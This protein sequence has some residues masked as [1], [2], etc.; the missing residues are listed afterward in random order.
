MKTSRINKVLIKMILSATTAV[1]SNNLSIV[2]SDINTLE[3][4]LK[5]SDEIAGVQFCINTSSDITLGELE[6]GT[7]TLEPHWLVSSHKP[8]DSTINVVIF[9]IQQKVLF[10]GEGSLVKINFSLNCIK[11][12]SYAY[13]SKVMVANNKAESL[14][15]EVSELMWNN[16]T[17]IAANELN[18][19]FELGQNYPNPF[20]PA[21]KIT[22]KLNKP[23]HVKLS[24]YDIR[25]REINRLVD[26]Y[27]EV[28]N[29]SVEWN[30]HNNEGN[31][32]SSGIYIAY[33]NVDGQS[34]SRK[35][36]MV[37]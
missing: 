10:K 4:Q 36:M 15:V 26:K 2:K 32:L 21:T 13:L 3:V 11:E 22:Y 8:N 31:T 14:G 29:Y 12:K 1:A 25:G 28:G 9:S 33:L 19:F 6:R 17:T 7:L 37:K 20:N 27:Q 23:A 5:N 16:N 34:L 30:T 24:I 18:E 35:M